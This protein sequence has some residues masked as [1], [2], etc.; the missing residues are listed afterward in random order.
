MNTFPEVSGNRDR[1]IN[2][3]T[4]PIEGIPNVRM[5]WDIDVVKE[6][7]GTGKRPQYLLHRWTEIWRGLILYRQPRIA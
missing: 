6:V 3:S 5:M 4:F 2:T 7:I 1:V